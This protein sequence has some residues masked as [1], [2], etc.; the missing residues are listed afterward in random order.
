MSA[1]D[2]QPSLFE[3]PP[4]A[5]APA[6]GIEA[7]TG[8]A[9]Q[10]PALVRLGGM[11]WTYPGWRGLV[12]AERASQEAITRHGLTAYGKH[13]LFRAVEI[14][15]SYYDPLYAEIYA[16]FAA[17]V[18]DDFRFVVKAHEDCVV[19]RY[20]THARY[21]RLRGQVN[22]RYLDPVYA[23]ERVVSQAAQ[24]LGEKLGA[25]LFQ[26]PPHEVTSPERFADELHGFLSRLPG[27]VT[28]AVELRNPELLTP[29]YVEAL[30]STGAVHCHNVWG[31]M[32]AALAQAKLVSPKA[33]SPL[34]VRWLLRRGDVYEG[35]AERFQPFDRLVEEDLDARDDVARLTAKAAAHG[36]PCTV[37][38]S[39]HVEGCAPESIA[40][41]AA[42]VVDRS[43]ALAK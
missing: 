30:A 28:Y 18:P 39:N 16:R 37:L 40:R 38:V 31:S 19:A 1:A 7:F 2:R 14:D 27:G 29:R 11:S 26:L 17:Q 22:A 24:G 15:R 6:E 10:L 20:P 33:R 35:A 9:A 25:V 12:Y 41:L 4:P 32:P 42:A 3:L 43:A 13:P 36:V 23:G 5:V 34:L 8:L 21:G